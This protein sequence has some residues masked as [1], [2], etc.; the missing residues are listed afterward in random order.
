MPATTRSDLII[1]EV[2]ADAVAGAWPNRIALYGTDAVVESRSLPGEVRGGDKVKV[3]YFGILGE[4][5]QVNEGAP[6]TVTRLTMTAEEAQV[7]RAG[8]AFEI[9]TWAQMAAMYADPYAEAV[10]QIVEGARR[11]FDRALVEAAN[12]TTGGG[13]STEDAST[14]T[15][16]YDAI[17]NAITRFGDAQVDI[18]AVVVHSKVLGDLRKL[19]DTTGLPI[20]V[21]AQ[22]GG[23]PRVLGLPLIVS[24][25]APVIT[26]TP[27]RYVTLFVR[28]GALA[29]WYN[30]TPTVET[31]RDILADSTV[32]AVNIYYAAHRYSR[33]PGD[34]KPT[35]VRLI[36]Q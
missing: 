20:F 31:D 6:L 1:P 23:L 27:T 25:R 14:G 22:Q 26:G 13:V 30:G 3:P 2:L 11:E 8:K 34:D 4:F 29:L 19:K 7:R 21:D 16:T 17:V 33:L 15:I 10:R 36:T 9:T 32:V 28:R 12:S 5:E 35:V 24:D 18:A